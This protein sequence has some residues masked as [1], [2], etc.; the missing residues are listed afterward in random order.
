MFRSLIKK[1]NLSATII[2]FLILFFILVKL[3]PNCIFNKQG[4]LRNFGLGKTNTTILPIWLLVIVIAIISYLSI[5]YY[6]L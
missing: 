3:K 6:L 4:S 5:V 2:L 1:N